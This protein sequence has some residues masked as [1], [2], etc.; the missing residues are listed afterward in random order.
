M[1]VVAMNDPARL[2]EQAIEALNAGRWIEA[3]QRAAQLAP[4]APRHGGVH[5]IAGVAALGLQ[6]LPLALGHL[7]RAAHYNPERADYLAQYARALAVAFRMQDALLVA[8]AA[9]RLPCDDAVTWDTLG[10]IYGRANLHA[11]AAEAFRRAVS[12]APGNADFRF[13][14]ATSLTFHGHLDAAEEEF[15]ACI[16]ADPRH[17]RAH[18]WLAQLRK[19]APDRNHVDRLEAI[20]QTQRHDDDAQLYLNVALAKE[21]EDL[22]DYPRAFGHYQTGK[23]VHR[24]RLGDADAR[25]AAMFDA[26]RRHFDGIAGEAAG[27]GSEEPIF[28]MGMPRTGTTLVD[29]ILSAH[30]DVHSAGELNNFGVVVRSMAQRPARTLAGTLEGLDIGGLDWAKMGRDYVESTRPNTGRTPRFT[31][32][33]PHNFLYAGFI[34]RALPNAR[35]VCL[36]RDPMDTCLSNFRQLF[37]LDSPNYDYSYD[38]LDAG[39]YYLQFDR[40]MRYW[41]ETMPGR[42]LELE[43]ESLVGAQAA[44]TRGLLE[45]CGL[46]WNELCLGFED[47]PAPVATA[48]AVQVRS[49]MNRDSLRR[50]K[51][52]EAQLAPLR[53]LLEDAGIHIRD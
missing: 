53:R 10:V 29:R 5:Y 9:T 35:I 40:L 46:P 25:D 22:G 15:E 17:W 41:R 24:R 19:Q 32:K 4:G 27:D 50:W 14:L 34:A 33:L 26:I 47:N 6:Q 45:F 52:Y 39:R 30:P 1:R 13:N 37:A 16:A 18:L 2:Y 48:S 7:Q 49:G 21:Y 20:I 11:R 3:Q 51:R 8:D 43:Y 36:R 31:D 12:L 38:I 28:V 42:I 44:C 23:A